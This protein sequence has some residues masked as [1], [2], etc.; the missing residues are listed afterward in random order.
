M[1]FS[2]IGN[3][4]EGF[5][6]HVDDANNPAVYDNTGVPYGNGT[7]EVIIEPEVSA[8]SIVVTRNLA[9]GAQG[10][11]TL[12]EVEVFAGNFVIP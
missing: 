5:A 9:G 10:Y 2:D 1:N 7:F 3:Q 12:C 4:L 8:S 11:I 6:V